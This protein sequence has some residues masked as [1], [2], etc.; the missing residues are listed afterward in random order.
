MQVVH[1]SD[2]HDNSKLIERI[3]YEPGEAVVLTGDLL[4][5]YGRQPKISRKREVA[6]QTDLLGHLASSWLT[7]FRG[8]P[9]IIVRGNHDFIDIKAVL[10][11][12]G[13]NP[14]LIHQIDDGSS[15]VLGGLRFAGFREIPYIEGEWEGEAHLFQDLIDRTWEHNPDVLVTH[16]PPGGILDGRGYGIPTLTSALTYQPHNIKV[17]LFGHTHEQGGKDVKELG[18]EFFNGACH[19]RSIR[20]A[21]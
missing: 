1:A 5:N 13:G 10:C 17:H 7:A 11:A 19:T 12:N 9:V 4:G 3:Y 21:E 15:V 8:R 6:Y 2:T 18:I 20:I 16:A 14:K